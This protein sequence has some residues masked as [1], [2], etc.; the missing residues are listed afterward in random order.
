MKISEKKIW[1]IGA[2]LVVLGSLGILLR[3]KKGSRR[4]DEDWQLKEYESEERRSKKLEWVK[5]KLET[6]KACLDK[7]I[8]KINEKINMRSHAT[9]ENA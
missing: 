8:K 2:G 5:N 7:H 6:R 9:S 4:W 1:W 3:R